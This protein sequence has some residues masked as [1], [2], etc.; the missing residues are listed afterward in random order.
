MSRESLTVVIAVLSVVLLALGGSL[1]MERQR[2]P[3]PA[4]VVHAALESGQRRVTLEVT[5]LSCASCASRVCEQLESTAGVVS[6]DVDASSSRAY[7]VCGE[8]VADSSL[9][10]A[11]TR[12]GRE[13]A[14]AVLTR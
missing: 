8:A 14:A 1:W 6:C 10:R 4:R 9:V 3:A 12:A 11:V 7:V 2:A 13:Y 5:G